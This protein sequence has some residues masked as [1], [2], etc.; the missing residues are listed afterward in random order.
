MNNQAYEN[1]S[2]F[3]F[4]FLSNNLRIQAG[5]VKLLISMTPN[6]LNSDVSTVFFTSMEI[7]CSGLPKGIV[8]RSIAIIVIGWASIV[9]GEHDD[10]VV[11]HVK[12]V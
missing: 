3:I 8:A 5:L 6:K 11:H 2:F 10:G 7:S 1:S 9:C 12:M 4:L